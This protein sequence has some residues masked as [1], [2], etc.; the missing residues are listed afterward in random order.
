M[1][2]KAGDEG[3]PLQVLF[4]GVHQSA[5][6]LKRAGVGRGDILFPVSVHKGALYVLA[7]VVMGD[8]IELAEY[9]VNHLGLD[10][11]SITGLY[12]YQIQELIQ[13]QCGRLGH[14]LPYGCDIEVALVD[15]STPL[16]FDRAVAPEQLSEISFCP[17]KGAPVG[18][19]YIKDGKLT[20][21][22]SLHGNVRRLCAASAK[23]FADLVGLS[24]AAL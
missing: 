15:R 23:L 4:G 2:R 24:E 7:G 14:R 9:A 16:K 22:L 19:K 10:S 21:A 12:E 20:S 13:K 5:P 8:F 18:L 17:R 11:S 3:K 6:S 1:L